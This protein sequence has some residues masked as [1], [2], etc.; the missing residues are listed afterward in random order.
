MPLAKP[1]DVTFTGLPDWVDGI[2]AYID[3]ELHQPWVPGQSSR[4]VT[5]TAAM[6]SQDDFSPELA[7]T[8]EALAQEYRVCGWSVTVV[9]SSTE[10]SPSD[11]PR[12]TSVTVRFSRWPV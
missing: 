7:A 4:D 11:P 3:G 9:D 5:L 12:A 10:G 2:Q 8:L 1:Y 6:L